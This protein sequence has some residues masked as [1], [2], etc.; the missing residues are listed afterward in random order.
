MERLDRYLSEESS[1]SRSE[2]KKLIRSGRVTVN[3]Q[4]EKRPEAKVDPGSD[5]ICADG[6]EIRPAG[7]I[8]LMMNKPAGYLS[9]TRDSRVKTV[10]DLIPEPFADRLFPVGRLD[11]DTEGLLLLTNDG[12]LAHD[13]TAPSRHVSKTYFAVIDGRPQEDMIR[14]FREGLDIG[15]KRKTLPALLMFPSV[16]GDF[17]EERGLL[18]HGRGQDGTGTQGSG[19]AVLPQ[20]HGRGPDAAQ[21]AGEASVLSGTVQDRMISREM[22]QEFCLKGI[23]LSDFA[24]CGEDEC[25]AAVS[26]TE[27]KYHQIKRMFGAAGREVHFL[28]RIA[29]AGLMLDPSLERGAYRRL[30]EEE[31]RLLQPGSSEL[32]RANPV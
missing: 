17:L 20:D 6:V 8:C 4:V 16:D 2:G 19:A 27:G 12:S 24:R 32:R 30:T 31:F 29:V 22:M 15:E 7:R 28:K 18:D 23:A 14:A 21:T 5:R 26:V 1:Y 11:K 25:C 9:A 3:G 10:I 13:L